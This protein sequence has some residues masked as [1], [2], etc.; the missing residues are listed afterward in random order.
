MV[1]RQPMLLSAGSGG[2]EK[3][4]RSEHVPW[5]T[6]APATGTRRMDATSP[7]LGNILCGGEEAL[8]ETEVKKRDARG[9]MD[10]ALEKFKGVLDFWVIRLNHG[11]SLPQRTTH[12]TRRPEP[13]RTLNQVQSWAYRDARSA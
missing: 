4:T 13:A 6:L 1:V 3:L 9:N 10:G 7:R 2:R 5:R 11:G 8:T 12:T